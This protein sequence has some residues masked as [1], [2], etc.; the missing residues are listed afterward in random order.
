MELAMDFFKKGKLPDE[1]FTLDPLALDDLLTVLR[2][3]YGI[4]VDHW[5]NSEASKYTTIMRISRFPGRKHLNKL[6]R[7]FEEAVREAEKLQGSRDPLDKEDFDGTFGDFLGVE[8]NL[9][10][11]VRGKRKNDVLD[12][13]RLVPACRVH[14]PVRNWFFFTDERPYYKCDIHL[15][16]AFEPFGGEGGKNAVTLSLKVVDEDLLAVT[17]FESRWKKFKK[18]KFLKKGVDLLRE[19]DER[20]MQKHREGKR[21]PYFNPAKPDWFLFRCESEEEAVILNGLNHTLGH[22]SFQEGD[23]VEFKME[24]VDF[25]GLISYL[26][27]GLPQ[28]IFLGPDQEVELS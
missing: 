11:A 12:V 22:E 2:Y 17:G 25:P 8:V 20:I 3:W 26:R 14:Y 7:Y 23:L 27:V 9:I 18:F 21:P 5:I 6:H 16:L 15:M 13:R 19:I 24:E 1:S 28:H 4:E 10:E